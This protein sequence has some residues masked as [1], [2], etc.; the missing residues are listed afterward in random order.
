MLELGK[1]SILFWIRKSKSEKAVHGTIMCRITYNMV[2]A[3]DFSTS[4]RCNLSDW[5]AQRQVLRGN[6]KEAQAMNNLLEMIKV[7]I[8][9]KAL[10]LE[11]AGQLITAD[12]LKDAYLGKKI[13]KRRLTFLEL[14][15]EYIE[16]QEKRRLKE[17]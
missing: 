15:D 5:N 10:E 11:A 13:K 17:K 1:L 8:K 9:H 7:G 16:W 14:C 4:V 3:N 12:A 2:R 6:S